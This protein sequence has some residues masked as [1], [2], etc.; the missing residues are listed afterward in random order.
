MD[1]SKETHIQRLFD[2]YC[3]KV[4]SNEAKDINRKRRKENEHRIEL[5]NIYSY[6]INDFLSDNVEN[7]IIDSFVYGTSEISLGL[8]KAIKSLDRLSQKIVYLYYFEN[9]NDREIGEFLDFSVGGIWYRRTRAIEKLRE[10][11]GRSNDE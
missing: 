3:K 7:K 9:Y 5:D 1:Y 6:H 10:Y 2:S 4:L 8:E 11:L